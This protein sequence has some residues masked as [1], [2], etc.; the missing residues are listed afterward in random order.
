MAGR[1]F[2]MFKTA[3]VFALPLI[4]LACAGA[5]HG[6]AIERNLP[7]A[8]PTPAQPVLG[9]NATP[10]DQDDRVIGPALSGLLLLGP[11][12]Q[13]R[14]A[15]VEGVNTALVGRLNLA[16]PRSALASF[17][18]KPL[19]RKLIADIESTIARYYR[20]RGYPFVSIS[21]PPQVIGRGMLQVRVVEFHAGAVSVAGV[22]GRTAERIR[23][24]VRLQPDQPI[25]AVDL[26]ADL[27]WLNRYPFRHIEAVFSPGDG[28]GRS[29]LELQDTPGRPWQAYA[30]YANSGSP[31]TG[32]DRYFL[33]GQVG[34][35]FG[36]GSFASY[37]FTASP[38]F[39]DNHGHIFD[40]TSHPQYI[41]HGVRVSIPTGDRQAFEATFDQV[42]SNI[43]SDPFVARQQT[44]ELS[45]GYRASVSN[46]VRLPGDLFGGVEV[47][48][49]KKTTLFGD[50]D[51]LHTSV[52]IY[53]LYAGW[54]NAWSDMGGRNTFNLV[55]HGSPGG[56]DTHNTADA[57]AIFSDGR[58][59]SGD[60]VYVT[61]QFSRTTRL[62]G[63]WTIS[64]TLIGQYAGRALPETEQMGVGG[65]DL[66]RGYTLD[67]GSYDAA[68]V[69]RNELRTPPFP[70]LGARRWIADQVSPYAFIDAAYGSSR[71]TKVDIHPASVGLGADYDL[72]SHF[73]ASATIAHDL[74]SGV[75][76][77]NGDW[78]LQSRITLSY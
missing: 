58:V 66:V 25:D 20:R 78:Q 33:G 70:L 9:P 11:D 46:L 42:E 57:F 54:A 30:G 26:T 71:V 10:S 53:Q 69:S 39:F 48:T 1:R 45:L 41:S 17:L 68:I 3:V 62:P 55:V 75:R 34:G 22:H 27:D 56:I 43:V 74:S 40:D 5:A 14:T 44:D 15:P 60:Y 21:T 29:N 76:T 19:S 52:N 51:V 61:A 23:R 6:Q 7:P 12:D 67:D 77:R 13:V 8:P 38:D 49:E 63:R 2:D 31:A 73:S 50:V 35:V 47:K 16:A 59:T 37:Q 36:P 65:Q 64:N 32:W 72:S 4:T 24:G 18:G 28:L